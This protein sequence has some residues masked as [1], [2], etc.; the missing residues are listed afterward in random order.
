[1]LRVGYLAL[2]TSQLRKLVESA[3]RDAVMALP[4][5]GAVAP[6]SALATRRGESAREAAGRRMPAV[7][8]R[9]PPGLRDA[10]PTN[11]RKKGRL[12]G[13]EGDPKAGC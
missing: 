4:S 6:A 13:Q 11:E 12:P 3:A 8:S 10:S 7:A 2:V 1:M 5:T 9:V